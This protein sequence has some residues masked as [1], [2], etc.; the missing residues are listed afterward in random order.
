MSLALRLPIL[1]NFGT[2]SQTKIATFYYNKSDNFCLRVP[3]EAP[4]NWKLFKIG[5]ASAKDIRKDV[6]IFQV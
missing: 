4:F 3:P 2:N 1:N 5:M 6:L